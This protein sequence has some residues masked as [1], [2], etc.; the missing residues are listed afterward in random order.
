MKKYIVPQIEIVR[1]R[2]QQL[3]TLSSLILED[4]DEII[5]DDPLLIE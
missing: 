2:P 1:I 5:I 3:L 4:D